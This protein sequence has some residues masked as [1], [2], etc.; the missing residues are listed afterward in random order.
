MPFAAKPIPG[1]PREVGVAPRE[2]SPKTTAKPSAGGV[3]GFLIVTVK[4][5][6]ILPAEMSVGQT[7]APRWLFSESVN[8]NLQ[9]DW[10]TALPSA[11]QVTLHKLSMPARGPTKRAAELLVTEVVLP[12]LTTTW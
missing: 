10:A 7:I 9:P 4:L 6:W 1:A 3:L 5:S 12:L 2:G 11:D 8:W